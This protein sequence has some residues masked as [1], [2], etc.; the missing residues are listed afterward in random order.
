MF[1]AGRT[2]RRGRDVGQVSLPVKGRARFRRRVRRL[3]R[4]AYN[5]GSRSECRRVTAHAAFFPT[6]VLRILNHEASG[7]SC[8]KNIGSPWACTMRVHRRAAFRGF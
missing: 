1:D 2:T 7:C 4:V 3:P 6:R 8:E 5:A